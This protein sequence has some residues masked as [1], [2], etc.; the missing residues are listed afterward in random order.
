[1]SPICVV[2]PIVHRVSSTVPPT[3]SAGCY[4]PSPSNPIVMEPAGGISAPKPLPSMDSTMNSTI[5]QQHCTGDVTDFPQNSPN[6][7]S[8]TCSSVYPNTCS[9]ACPTIQ[10]IQPV[11]IY[12][13]NSCPSS[14]TKSSVLSACVNGEQGGILLT[15]MFG[16]NAAVRCTCSKSHCLQRYCKCLRAGRRCSAECKC[17][18]CHNR[19]SITSS[20]S[21]STTQRFQS[22]NGS[23]STIFPFQHNRQG[24]SMQELS[25]EKQSKQSK[26]PKQPLNGQLSSSSS[27][28]LPQNTQSTPTFFTPQHSMDDQWE[29]NENLVDY[30]GLGLPSSSMKNTA[31]HH[32]M[33]SPIVPSSIPPLWEVGEFF[34]SSNSSQPPPVF[35]F[36]E[37][38]TM[39]ESRLFSSTTSLSLACKQS[40]QKQFPKKRAKIVQCLHVRGTKSGKRKQ[41]LSSCACQKSLCNKR[42]CSC[43]KSGQPCSDNCQCVDCHNQKHGIF[44]V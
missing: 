37:D 18:N 44:Y 23:Q 4:F 5:R 19:E 42:S 3:T 41:L 16:R 26:Q 33:L 28:L 21:S 39:T 15:E 24:Y 7:C 31:D 25:M 40:G 8:N 20:R 14:S 29:R 36:V 9:N 34:E 2:P 11:I 43:Y 12:N 6:T 38:G 22:T 13:T 32:S 10:V 35:E 1:M 27:L 17:V 30:P